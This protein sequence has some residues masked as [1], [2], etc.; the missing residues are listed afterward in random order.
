MNNVSLLGRT[1]SD[2]EL[3][4]TMTGKSVVNFTLAVK[5]KYKSDETDFIKCIAWNNTAEFM[6]RY[7]KKGQ[8]IAV[9]GSLQVRKYTTQN[10]ENRTATEVIVNDVYFTG[11]K[12]GSNQR[13]EKAVEEEIQEFEDLPF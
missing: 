8:M 1:T 13:E 4:T 9:D 2:I 7:I 5:R 11:D 6:H 12:S 3:K 10:G